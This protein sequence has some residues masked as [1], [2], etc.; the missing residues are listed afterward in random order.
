MTK[1]KESSEP[2]AKD[3]AMEEKYHK[4]T[5]RLNEK[6]QNFL[7]A[8]CKKEGL[9][10]TITCVQ[11]ACSV[12]EIADD[13]DGGASAIIGYTE[14]LSDEKAFCDTQLMQFIM[15]L[16]HERDKLHD[17]YG[18]GLAVSAL[19]GLLGMVKEEVEKK[20]KK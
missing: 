4:S 7:K 19:E 18:D 9:T 17:K 12:D 20:D 16:A 14:V 6:I 10:L 5:K 13:E 8:E 3:K 11:M 15:K 2:N 1:T